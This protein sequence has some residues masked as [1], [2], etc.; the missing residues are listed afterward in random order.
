MRR[1]PIKVLTIL[2]LALALAPFVATAA[3][4][5]T[6]STVT[7]SPTNNVIADGSDY[8]TITVTVR[9]TSNAVMAGQTIDYNVIGNSY[10]VNYSTLVSDT[11][12][13]VTMTITS[14]KAQVKTISASVGAVYFTQ[15]AYVTFIA[16]AVDA[17]HSTATANPTTGVNADGVDSSTVTVTL[18]DVHDNLAVGKTVTLSASGGAN[19]SSPAVTDSSGVTTGTVTSTTSGTKTVT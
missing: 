4:S 12:G 13:I 16:A 18:K 17:G 9:D 15:V 10:E 19:C 11:N 7:C 14:T 3:V 8:S 6:Y 1:L 2:L 5:P